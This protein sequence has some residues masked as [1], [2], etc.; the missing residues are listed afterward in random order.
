MTDKMKEAHRILARVGLR[1]ANMQDALATAYALVRGCYP[2]LPF[3]L[4]FLC[5]HLY[6]GVASVRTARKSE[7]GVRVLAH[8]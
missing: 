6:M 7:T 5:G 2:S 4:L 1:H 3:M 8:S